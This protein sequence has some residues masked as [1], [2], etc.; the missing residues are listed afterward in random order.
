MCPIF[1]VL[2]PLNQTIFMNE[3]IYTL[4]SSSNAKQ[5]LLIC[6]PD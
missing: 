6:L 5:L 3:Y 1:E 2:F 4:Y